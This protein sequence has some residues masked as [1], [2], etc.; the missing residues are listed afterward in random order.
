MMSATYFWLKSAGM[1]FGR[2]VSANL[3]FL[4]PR[5]ESSFRFTEG[6]YRMKV[7]AQLL[8]DRERIMLFSQTLTSSK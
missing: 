5:D 2:A 8:G 3:H 7:F 6:R 4:A 1:S